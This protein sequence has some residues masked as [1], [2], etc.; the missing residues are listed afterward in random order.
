MNEFYLVSRLKLSVLNCFLLIPR[1]LLW[2]KKQPDYE[3][4]H[5]LSSSV[6]VMNMWHFITT[7]SLL[8]W[9]TWPSI[10]LAPKTPLPF[11]VAEIS[12][13]VIFFSLRFPYTSTFWGVGKAAYHYNQRYFIL[14]GI[15]AIYWPW[16]LNRLCSP[17]SSSAFSSLARNLS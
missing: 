16:Q 14:V 8:L 13:S 3:H 15:T 12:K 17:F 5:P 9:P 6:R 1:I 11:S 7:P 2:E 10:I 4:D